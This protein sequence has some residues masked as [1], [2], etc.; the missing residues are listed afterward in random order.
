MKKDYNDLTKEEFLKIISNLEDK[1]KRL[2]KYGLVW[3]KEKEPEKIVVDCEKNIPILK[4]DNTKTII[5]DN[6]DDNILIE[7]DNYHA[8]TVLN[9]THKEKVDVIYIDP[10]YNTGN[11]NEWKYN[12]KYVDIN[13]NY[14]HSKW[15][16]MMDKR[17][18]LAKNLLKDSGII[19][20]SIDDHEQANLKLLC[21]KIF[22]ETNHIA[23]LP[24]VMNLKGNND[25]FGFS[26]C[27]EYTIVY[28]KNKQNCFINNFPVENELVLDEWDIDEKGY[29]KKGSGLLATSFGKY[30]EERPYMYFPILIKNNKLYMITKEEYQKIYDSNKKNFND[31]FVEKLKIKYQ[32]LGYFVLLPIDSNNNH[33]RWT[34]SFDGKFSTYIDD[35]IITKTKNSFTLNKKQRPEL[36]DLPTKKPKSIFYKPEYSSSNGTALLFNIFNKRLELNPKPLD[37]IKDIIFLSS[38][39]TA[40]ILDFF[41]G[42]GTTG[43]AVLKINKED[44]GNRKFILCTNN[45]NKICEDICYQR[46]KKVIEGYKK[47][48]NGNKIDGLG[49]NLKYFKT[50]LIS[51][52]RIDKVSDKKRIEL[53]KKAGDMIGFKEAT[54]E[55][56]ELNDFYQ[57]F[58]NKEKT[59]ITAIYFREDEELFT[60]LLKK[61]DKKKSVLYIFSYGKIDRKMYKNLK[62]NISIEDIPQPIL[63][64]YKEINLKIEDK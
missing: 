34:W 14:K 15:L 62:G 37:L 44:G 8:L 57:I 27:H 39:K 5:S 48:G 25:Q 64:I 49:G 42:S 1:I 60:E 13:D 28:S 35:V 56:L 4:I 12:D 55:Q 2:N 52:E 30:R 24:T 23:T 10:P 46:I 6:S 11:K 19:F 16:N 9:Y 40:V 26:G 53:T 61:I 33:L 22:D 38:S 29:Y 32:R 47:N 58:T 18:S 21:D 7:G 43:H 59:K 45:E 31:I 41:A 63:D 36:G 17:L 51:V 54:L 3:D 20:I 50:D